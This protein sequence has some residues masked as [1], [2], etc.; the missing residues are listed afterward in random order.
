[1]V[2]RVLRHLSN[3]G[4]DPVFD[5]RVELGHMAFQEAD[6]R[7]GEVPVRLVEPLNRRRFI[8]RMA[9]IGLLSLL[10][11]LR[12]SRETA[13][14]AECWRSGGQADSWPLPPLHYGKIG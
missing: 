2:D 7:I 14:G 3:A 13:E 4:A 11:D 5:F 1:V 6:D 12:H 10:E 9:Q 8:V